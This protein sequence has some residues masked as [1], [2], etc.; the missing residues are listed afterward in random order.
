MIQPEYEVD[1]ARPL[2][3]VGTPRDVANAAAHRATGSYAS[4]ER[5]CELPKDAL[6]WLDI[7][8]TR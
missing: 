1:P 8:F 2:E 5:L 7:L 6:D 3:R 4:S